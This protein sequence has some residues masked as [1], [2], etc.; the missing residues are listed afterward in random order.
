MTVNKTAAEAAVLK[1]FKEK[2][3]SKPSRA[4]QS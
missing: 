1:P 4:N 2:G 3:F